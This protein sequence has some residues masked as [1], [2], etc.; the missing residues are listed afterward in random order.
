[1]EPRALLTR[2]QDL[3]A[4]AVSDALDALGGGG[5]AL[6]PRPPTT[7]TKICGRVVTVRLR[8]AR[9]GEVPPRHLGSAA[10]EASGPGDVI[11]I[12]HGGRSDVSGWGGNLSIAAA[13][14]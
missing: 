7:Q 13:A 14:R 1:M 4:W 3:D 8:P 2:L 10:V 5:A 12:D 6:G 11:V 9:R